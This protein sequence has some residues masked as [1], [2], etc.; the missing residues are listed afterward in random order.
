MVQ[1]RVVKVSELAPGEIK[2]VDVD[3]VAVCVVHSEGGEFFAMRDL[4]SH[5]AY[6][7]SDGWTYGAEIECGHHNAIFDMKTGEALGLPATEP[8]SIYPVS[9]DG[10][11]VVVTMDVVADVD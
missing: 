10:E 1:H 9:I 3:G 6:P 8:I 4:C 7:L 5:E 11:D 2:R